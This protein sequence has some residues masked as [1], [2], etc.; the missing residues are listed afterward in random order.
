MNVSIRTETAGFKGRIKNPILVGSGAD[1]S[2]PFLVTILPQG[3]RVQT[4][5]GAGRSLGKGA[6]IFGILGGGE[7]VRQ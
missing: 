3:G 2:P 1:S 5:G 6:S 7:S 4:K